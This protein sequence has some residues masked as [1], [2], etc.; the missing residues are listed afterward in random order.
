MQILR[1]EARIYIGLATM[2]LLTRYLY[3]LVTFP[4]KKRSPVCVPRCHIMST[5]LN[6]VTMYVSWYHL[7]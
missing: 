6:Y 5:Y 4:S 7:G 3:Y 2:W 1:A